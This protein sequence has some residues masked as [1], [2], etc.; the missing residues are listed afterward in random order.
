MEQNK[1]KRMKR[2]EESLKDLWGNIKHTNI[3]IIEVS[4]GED[5][6]KRPEKIFEDII[7][8]TSLTW[9]RKEPPKSRKCR[10]SQAG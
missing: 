5:R 8:K 6:E 1:E 3:S 4:E 9:E 7:V 2:N 10:E